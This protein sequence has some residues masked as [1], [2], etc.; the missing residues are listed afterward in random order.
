VVAQEVLYHTIPAQ[1]NSLAVEEIHSMPDKPLDL[2]RCRLPLRQNWEPL[3]I[4]FNGREERGTWMANK[5]PPGTGAK[6]ERIQLG[7]MTLVVL[8]ENPP[9]S[10][11]HAL[12]RSRTLAILGSGIG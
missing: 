2:D 9:H 3:G 11:I 4:P 5:R 8:A 7:A 6:S 12:S 1:G 10:R